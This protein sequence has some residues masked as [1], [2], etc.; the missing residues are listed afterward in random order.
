MEKESGDRQKALDQA[1]T[2]I[3]REFGKG[4]IMRLGAEA[5]SL[6]VRNNLAVLFVYSLSVI[7]MGV[8]SFRKNMKR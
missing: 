8:F 5:V 3:E 2:Q 1:I 4:S 6:T 7:I